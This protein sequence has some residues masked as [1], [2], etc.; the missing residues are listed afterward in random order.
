MLVVYYRSLY[1]SFSPS[2]LRSLGLR[3]APRGS[4]TG[5]CWLECGSLRSLALSACSLRAGRVLWSVLQSS[6]SWV[7]SSR[8]GENACQ[9]R[10][11]IAVCAIGA[12]V[13]APSTFGTVQHVRL[14]QRAHR[15]AV[16]ATAAPLSVHL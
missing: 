8:P 7:A 12:G 6:D 1:L 10:A 2:S 3:S 16:H 5:A 4:C 9:S 13:V 11:F 15:G 14:L